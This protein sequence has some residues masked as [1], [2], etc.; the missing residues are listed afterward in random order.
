MGE[1]APKMADVLGIERESYYRLERQ[2]YKFNNEEMIKLAAAI[3]I[4]PYQ[5][6]FPPGAAK[7]T[8]LNRLISDAPAETQAM[9]IKA[10]RGM[11]GK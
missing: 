7:E 2:P 9:I 8:D 5:F 10:V 6:W 4:D 3:G 1:K 11:I